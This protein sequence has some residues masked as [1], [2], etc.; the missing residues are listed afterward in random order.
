MDKVTG[1]A[2][3]AQLRHRRMEVEITL[4]HLEKEKHQVESNT[5]WLNYAAYK[6]R[7]R[8][9]DRVTSWYRNEMTE[10]DKALNTSWTVDSVPMAQIRNLSNSTYN[11][12]GK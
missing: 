12:R 4:R 2:H 7:V 10:I 5:E 8:F 9:L 11:V 3:T 1:T 6:S